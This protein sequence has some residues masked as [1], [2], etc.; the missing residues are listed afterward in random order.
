MSRKVRFF[1]RLIIIQLLCYISISFALDKAN[2]VVKIDNANSYYFWLRA[3]APSGEESLINI[4]VDEGYSASLTFTDNQ[5][6]EWKKVSSAFYLASGS[7]NISLQTNVLGTYIDKFIFTADAGYTPTGEGESSISPAS[8]SNVWKE[9]DLGGKGGILIMGDVNDD[10]KIDFVE[11]GLNYISAYDNNGSLLWEKEISGKKLDY[12]GDG[13]WGCRPI[14]ID[15]DNNTEV[16]G[17]VCINDSLFLAALDGVT[18]DVESK[19]F[20][21][22][23]SGDWY[24][25]ATAIGN[26]RGINS[27]QDFMIKVAENGYVPFEMTVY[28]F[29]NGQ[30]EVLWEFFSQQGEKRAGCHRP[31]VCD[32]D[33]DGYDEI[34]FGHWALEENGDVRW[35]KPYGFFDENNHIDSQRAGDILPSN[36]GIEVAY[37]SGSLVLDA[38]GNVV[39][40]KDIDEGQS[41]ALAE[42]RPDLPG[43]EILIAYQEPYN[44]ERLFSSDGTQLWHFDGKNHYAASYETYPIQWIGDEGRESVRQPWGRDRSPTIYDEYNNLV[45]RL[46]PEYDYWEIG[47]RPCDVTGDYREE[48][49][50]FSEDYIIIYENIAVNSRSFPSPWNDPV[51]RRNQYNWVY[52]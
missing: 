32:I 36:P 13:A 11:S 47:Y 6:F 15:G 16:V 21:K 7:H 17:L 22:A 9:I 28:K 24:Y 46:T 14:D 45:V 41:V 51:Y 25:D 44:D 1:N 10:G 18:G 50:C 26:F 43:L 4:A 5:N 8:I 29:E 48:L 49:I 38:D 40:R 35:D 3:K 42:M 19:R 31:R 27:P 37:A 39:W 30:F 52:Y 23:V 20:L 2:Y 33:E 34:I 12:V